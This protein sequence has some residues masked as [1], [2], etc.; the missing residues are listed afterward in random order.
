MYFRNYGLPKTPL[1][2]YLK[3]AV[4][5]YALTSNIVN[6]LKHCSNLQSLAFTIIIDQ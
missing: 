6:A 5:H 1:K 4:S 3:S 2:K